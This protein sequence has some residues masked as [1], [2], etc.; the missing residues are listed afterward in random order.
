[1]PRCGS[2]GRS[3]LRAGSSFGSGQPR[4]AART[5]APQFKNQRNDRP[6]RF[7]ALP[8][9]NFALLIGKP[10]ID[11]QRIAP[12]PPTSTTR[13]SWHA[14]PTM[15]STTMLHRPPSVLENTKNAGCAPN[16]QP[17]D[18]A[19]KITIRTSLLATREC[20]TEMCSAQIAHVTYINFRLR[21]QT[22]GLNS[23]EIREWA[24]VVSRCRTKM[25]R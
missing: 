3:G 10:L 13:L 11:F 7:S 1:M 14:G 25:C 22:K 24:G 16:G 19:G 20:A 17:T 4:G 18:L 12:G 9:N 6:S 15:P 2:S 21:A 8:R 23:L 5:A